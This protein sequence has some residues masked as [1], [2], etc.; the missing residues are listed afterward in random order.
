[1]SSLAYCDLYLAL[2]A[3]ALRVYPKMQLY[4]TTEEDVKYDHDLFVPMP[5]DDGKCVRVTIV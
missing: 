4:E 3:V 2:A 5:R 1:M